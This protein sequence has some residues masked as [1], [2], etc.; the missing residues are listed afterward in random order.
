M[1][2]TKEELK[3]RDAGMSA[4]QLVQQY[5]PLAKSYA[6][7]VYKKTGAEF[8]DLLQEALIG[9]N[10]AA[11]RWDPEQN[12][13]FSTYALYWI[14]AYVWKFAW[15]NGE[16]PGGSGP[17]FYDFGSVLIEAFGYYD[18]TSD[19]SRFTGSDPF[20]LVFDA[21][22]GY[23]PEGSMTPQCNVSD[24]TALVEV[25]LTYELTHECPSFVKILMAFPL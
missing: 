16:G 5:I 23:E 15:D 7:K 10:H 12:T 25:R 4:A 20:Q 19:F 21:S 22:A 24:L 18:T 1:K 6:Q 13:L 11:S 17:D 8:D 3:A 9:I 14:R 2:V